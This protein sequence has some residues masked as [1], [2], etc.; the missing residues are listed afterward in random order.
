MRG[1]KEVRPAAV[2]DHDLQQ[3]SDESEP[4]QTARVAPPQLLGLIPSW[5]FW[6]D[7]GNWWLVRGPASVLVG[8]IAFIVAVSG[9]PPVLAALVAI[10]MFV[11]AMGLLERTIRKHVNSLG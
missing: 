3:Q 10:V 11:F 1:A 7:Q 4:E 6:S 5:G 2:T 9:L 8:I